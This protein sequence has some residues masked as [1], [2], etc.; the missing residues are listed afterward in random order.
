M[1]VM[2]LYRAQ[3]LHTSAEQARRYHLYDSA[4]QLLLVADQGSP[5]LPEDTRRSVRLARPD[6]VQVASLDF[7]TAA[8]KPGKGAAHALMVEHAVY[9][10]ITVTR[11]PHDG[12]AAAPRHVI[13]IEGNRWIGERPEGVDE[14]ALLLALYD[15]GPDAADPSAPFG[16]LRASVIEPYD[17]EAQLPPAD[18]KYPG[19]LAL[20]LIYLVDAG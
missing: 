4:D 5:W 15:S 19:L 7:P 1:R 10:L 8:P 3:R 9:A 18:L 2:P 14:D 11:E 20:A 6:G 16:A 13:E 17:I 12:E